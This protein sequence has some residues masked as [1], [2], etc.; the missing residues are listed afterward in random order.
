MAENQIF[1]VS[2]GTGET[3]TKMSKAALLQFQPANTVFARHSNVRSAEEIDGIARKAHKSRAL[4]IHTFASS[5]LRLAMENA[6]Q[7]HLV[8]SHDVLGG[9]FDRLEQFT[10][11]SAREEPG[12]LHQVDDDYFERMDALTFAVRHDDS[13]DPEGIVQ[14][15]IV[16]VGVSRT[17]KTPL[18]IYLAQEGW[19]VANVAVVIGDELPRELEHIDPTRV[20]G[21]TATPERLAEIREARLQR[22][23]SETSTYADISRVDE[24]LQHC[25]TIFDRHPK[26]L[27]IDVSRKSVE[28]TAAEILDD[29]FG[30]E[31]HL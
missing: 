14:A 2:D 30:K 29:L 6:C 26:W 22:L 23:G 31:R 4:V 11:L 24:E 12:L 10:G 9:L 19:K 17:S 20:I 3:A 5:S 21:L 16:L 18:S 7:K 27:I 8:P 25:K 13:R 28:E 1:I 15:D